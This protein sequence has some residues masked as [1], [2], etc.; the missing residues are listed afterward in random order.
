MFLKFTY[1]EKVFRP[2]KI[3]YFST[4]AEIMYAN[5]LLFTVEAMS[6][7]NL[8]AVFMIQ[9]CGRIRSQ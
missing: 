6:R 2:T 3:A 7:P 5:K 1:V 9:V 8:T 4:R